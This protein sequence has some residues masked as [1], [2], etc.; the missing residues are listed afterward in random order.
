ML[1]RF[2][3]LFGSGIDKYRWLRR[4]M[5]SFSRIVAALLRSLSARFVGLE[6]TT[7]FIHQQW[8]ILCSQRHRQQRKMTGANQFHRTQTRQRFFLIMECLLADEQ[9]RPNSQQRP[10]DFRQHVVRSLTAQL[11]AL[12]TLF[13][14][15]KEHFDV[16]SLTVQH[17]GLLIRHV[18]FVCHQINGL[19]AVVDLDQTKDQR[20][21]FTTPRR[22]GPVVNVAVFKMVFARF[23]R[24]FTLLPTRNRNVRRD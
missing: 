21:L 9:R 10:M 4:S 1:P 19:L 11:A 17:A 5:F 24:S 14:R 15:P 12:A 13:N 8:S 18:E 6:R 7:Q 23:F 3:P 2:S 20:L 22:I 16:P